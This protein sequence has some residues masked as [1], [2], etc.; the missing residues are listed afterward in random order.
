MLAAVLVH[1][2]TAHSVRPFATRFFRS[3]HLLFRLHSV[4]RP[5]NCV[6]CNHRHFGHHVCLGVLFERYTLIHNV[7]VYV[8]CG[9]ILQSCMV[10]VFDARPN[11]WQSTLS[12]HATVVFKWLSYV[13]SSPTGSIAFLVTCTNAYTDKKRLSSMFA[14]IIFSGTTTCGCWPTAKLLQS[15]A[16][17]L[18]LL[19]RVRRAHALIQSCTLFD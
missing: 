18:R 6:L 5:E 13:L 16:S 8:Y 2:A 3:S 9:L 15:V 10:S 12:L 1:P 11:I 7:L 19:L 14:Q 17:I 4:C